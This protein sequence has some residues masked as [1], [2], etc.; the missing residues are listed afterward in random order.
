MN[1]NDDIFVIN[2]DGSGLK[3]ITISL[4]S[5]YN[6]SWSPDGARG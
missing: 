2:A 6:P 4:A 5:D 1:G 3:R